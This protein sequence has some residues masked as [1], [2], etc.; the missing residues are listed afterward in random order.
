MDDGLIH[1][2]TVR[3]HV[4][5]LRK[6]FNAYRAAGLKLSPRKCSF[7]QDKIIFLGHEIRQDGIRPAESHVSAVQNWPLPQTKS[8]A[9]A[10][11]G[12]TNYY[13]DHI[14]EYARIAAPWTSVI[15]KTDKEAERTPLTLS[16]IHI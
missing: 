6:V 11:L 1:S 9:R 3:Q 13:R 14:L 7:F 2:F 10:F 8:Q 12:L 5:N 15:G 16:L 4:T